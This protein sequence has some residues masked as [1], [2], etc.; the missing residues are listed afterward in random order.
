MEQLRSI[1]ARVTGDAGTLLSCPPN[2]FIDGFVGKVEYLYQQSPWKRVPGPW[3][4]KIDVENRTRYA[5]ILGTTNKHQRGLQFF[6]SMEEYEQMNSQ[7]L[8]PASS[9]NFF[10]LTFEEGKKSQAT[11]EKVVNSQFV[12]ITWDEVLFCEVAIKAVTDFVNEGARMQ[13]QLIA[14]G[15]AGNPMVMLNQLTSATTEY[16]CHQRISTVSRGEVEICVTL[17]PSETTVQQLFFG[18]HSS[19]RPNEVIHLLYLLVHVMIT[20]IVG[21]HLLIINTITINTVAMNLT[22]GLHPSPSFCLLIF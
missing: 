6:D 4:L 16:P 7:P 19:N 10:L 13:A 20:F 18:Q 9:F 15:T 22:F 11:L 2:E 17:V 1:L 14:A 8:S 21:I 12:D 3:L 5:L